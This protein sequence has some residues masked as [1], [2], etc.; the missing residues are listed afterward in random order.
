MCTDVDDTIIAGFG[1]VMDGT[2]CKLG[3]NDMC[4]DGI[5]KVSNYEVIR[6]IP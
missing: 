2:P 5:C 4:I 1:D 3:T 6:E